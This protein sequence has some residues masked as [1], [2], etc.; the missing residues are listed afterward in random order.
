MDEPIRIIHRNFYAHASSAG[1]DG[2]VEIF[3]VID[4]T[5]NVEGVG[6]FQAVEEFAAFA[7]A[8]GVIHDGVDLADVGIDAKTEHH[9][10]Q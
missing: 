8:V 4:G 9:H 2:V 7:A 10:L 6:I 3:V 1:D 5:E